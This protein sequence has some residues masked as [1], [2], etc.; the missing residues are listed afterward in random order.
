MVAIGDLRLEFFL[1]T[2]S[3]FDAYSCHSGHRIFSQQIHFIEDS[4]VTAYDSKLAISLRLSVFALVLA[5]TFVPPSCDAQSQ[6]ISVVGGVR[7]HVFD[8]TRGVLL[9]S[10]PTS[11]EMWDV[12]SQSLLPPIA[13]IGLQLTGIDV[14]SDGNFAYVG[15][16]WL[17]QTSGSVYKVDLNTR[18]RKELKYTLDG[19]ETGVND[20]VILN[21]HGIFTTDF[22]GSGWNPLHEIDFATDEILSG[23]TIRENTGLVRGWSREYALLQEYNSSVGPLDIY[24]DSSKSIIEIEYMHKFI[25]HIP[26]AVNRSGTLYAFDNAILNSDL[27]RRHLL[28][29]SYGGY[30][31]DTRQNILYMADITTLDVIAFNADTMS[32]LGRIPIGESFYVGNDIMS[33][34][35]DSAYIFITTV[36]GIRQLTNPFA[37]PEPISALLLALGLMVP[38]R[39]R[40]V[41]SP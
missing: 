2:D 25:G 17:S 35:E 20:L 11:I 19:G 34:S 15:S 12:A 38:V 4:K 22:A 27:S 40:R 6:L 10:T 21:T 30:E 1:R 36:S 37:V 5:V 26:S 31:F 33:M 18:S 29:K 9:I 7:D 41:T 24:S 14:T 16:R 3:E 23:T 39:R 32:E 13:D 28:P 8:S